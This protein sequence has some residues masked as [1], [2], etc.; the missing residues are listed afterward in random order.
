MKSPIYRTNSARLDP[1]AGR[2]PP[3]P[4]QLPARSRQ[5]GRER[6]RS[7]S[8]FGREFQKKSIRR[9]RERGRQACDTQH[10]PAALSLSLTFSQ[11]ANLPNSPKKSRSGSLLDHRHPIHDHHFI[12]SFSST[13]VDVQ[14]TRCKT[15]LRDSFTF[16]LLLTH[17][18]GRGRIAAHPPNHTSLHTYARRF[19]F[20]FPHLHQPEPPSFDHS[21]EVDS[22]PPHLCIDTPTITSSN[23]AHRTCLDS[24]AR[25][26]IRAGSSSLC[27]LQAP[28]SLSL[29]CIRGDD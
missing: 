21:I 19:P 11:A 28:T 13:L 22:S 10:T 12:F 14:S 29:T 3:V 4:P 23:T 16:D 9:L 15:S 6:D 20:P 1:A 24:L 26:I 7:R 18:P 17:R 27:L 5:R 8:R 2:V 25:L